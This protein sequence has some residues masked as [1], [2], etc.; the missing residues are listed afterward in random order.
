[1][2]IELLVLTILVLLAA[3]GWIPYIIGVNTAAHDTT[4]FTRPADPALQRPWVHRAYRAHL[5]LLEQGV[6]FALL[7]LIL[8]HLDA[9]SA[10]T[11]WTCLAFLALRLVHGAGMISGMLRFPARPIVFT[12]GWLCCLILGYAVFAA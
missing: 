2:Q 10:L 9:F 11:A 1:M 5:N 3:S 12:L 8:A 4:D 6:P 7:V